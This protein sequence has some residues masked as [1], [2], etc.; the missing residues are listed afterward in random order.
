MNGIAGVLFR[1]RDGME[2]G[3]GQTNWFVS[4]RDNSSGD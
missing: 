2:V 4:S 3:N 1:V